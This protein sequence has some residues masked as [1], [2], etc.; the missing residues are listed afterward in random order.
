MSLLDQDITKSDQQLVTE[1]YNSRSG[2]CQVDHVESFGKSRRIHIWRPM[3]IVQQPITLVF[4][5]YHK[6]FHP[7]GYSVNTVLKVDT[8][9]PSEYTY[10]GDAITMIVEGEELCLDAFNG[11]KYITIY[12]DHLKRIY[13]T[14]TFY[15]HRLMIEASRL[16][17]MD[18]KVV[19]PHID[20]TEVEF[21]PML[22]GLQGKSKIFQSRMQDNI[23]IVG[24]AVLKALQYKDI[25]YMLKEMEAYRRNGQVSYDFPITRTWESLPSTI[26]Q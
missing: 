21:E 3:G 20:L 15:A 16:N 6:R 26:K 14:S 25:Q 8:P 19:I 5:H 22:L 18:M 11:T 9:F 2:V 10:N 17:R 23:T 1:W 13:S 7:E 4:D 24:E 12:G